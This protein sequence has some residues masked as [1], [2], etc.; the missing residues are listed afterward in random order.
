[1]NLSQNEGQTGRPQ[2]LCV[3][4]G[5]SCDAVVIRDDRLFSESI[6]GSRCIGNT[7]VFPS[8]PVRVSRNAPSV[9]AGFA[10]RT[11]ADRKPWRLPRRSTPTVAEQAERFGSA[12]FRMRNEHSSA[13]QEP[14]GSPGRNPCTHYRCGFSSML[15]VSSSVT[16]SSPTGWTA[17]FASPFGD[18]SIRFCN[19][20]AEGKV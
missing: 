4:A 10:G 15:S 13:A 8:G 11:R 18:T 7:Y 6:L 1:M 5:D 12:S 19:G 3:C 16:P 2:S 9:S 20:A 14:S 17:D